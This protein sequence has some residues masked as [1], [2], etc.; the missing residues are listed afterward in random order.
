MQNGREHVVFV[1]ADCLLTVEFRIIENVADLFSDLSSR[2]PD[3][4]QIPFD[5]AVSGLV[6]AKACKS[7]DGVN[8]SP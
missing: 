7:D 8:R 4:Y 3:G 1:I 5:F 2:I 6:Y